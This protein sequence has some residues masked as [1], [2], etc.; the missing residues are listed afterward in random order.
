MC[1]YAYACVCVCV[2]F[3]VKIKYENW[4]ISFAM[5]FNQLTSGPLAM[6]FSSLTTKLNLFTSSQLNVASRMNLCGSLNKQQINRNIVDRSWQWNLFNLLT[7][8]GSSAYPVLRL[9]SLSVTSGKTRR[10]VEGNSSC[11]TTTIDRMK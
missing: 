7:S 11:G 9:D 5:T 6:L 10:K 2:Y 8:V 4:Q 1:L 3:W